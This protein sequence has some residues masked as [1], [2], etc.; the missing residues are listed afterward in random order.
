MINCKYIKYIILL[1]AILAVYEVKGQ[2]KKIS[3]EKILDSTNSLDNLNRYYMNMFSSPV[4]FFCSVNSITL[5]DTTGIFKINGYKLLY[6]ERQIR[7]FLRKRPLKK[8]ILLE[9]RSYKIDSNNNIEVNII[10]S[11]VKYQFMRNYKF[12]K[13]VFINYVYKEFSNLK[14]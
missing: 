10:G 3:I 8:F 14:N 4:L 12:K 9:V 6:E 11:K 1:F 13:G 7:K 5:I 2:S